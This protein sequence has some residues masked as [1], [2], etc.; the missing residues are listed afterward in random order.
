MNK[1]DTLKYLVEN[2]E[3]NSEKSSST[4]FQI[5]KD[6]IQRNDQFFDEKFLIKLIQIAE[7]Y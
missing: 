1:L 5:L 2:F 7:K 3:D 6:I 4:M